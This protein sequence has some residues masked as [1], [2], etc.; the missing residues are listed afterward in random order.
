[1]TL[2]AIAAA[3]GTV[4]INTVKSAIDNST[5]SNEK[6]DTPTKTIGKD[7]KARQTVQRAIDEP[8]CPNGQVEPTKVLGKDGKARPTKYATRQD[9]MTLSA[10]AAADGTVHLDTVRESLNNST[11]GNP[12]VD[13]P[14]KTIGKDGKAR[15]G[16]GG[17]SEQEKDG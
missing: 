2:S 12:K 13:T 11:F 17:S 5:F 3:D 14:T 7:G 4:S 15:L 8:T 10:I 16:R 1:V 9:G 6:V